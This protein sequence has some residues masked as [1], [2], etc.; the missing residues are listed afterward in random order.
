M[1]RVLFNKLECSIWPLFVM[2]FQSFL[3]LNYA[4]YFLIVC[5]V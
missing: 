4:W 5:D 2:R 3:L 1:L